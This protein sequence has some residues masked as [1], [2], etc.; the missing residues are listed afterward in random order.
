MDQVNIRVEVP[1]T[2]KRTDTPGEHYTFGDFKVTR[3]KANYPHEA[4]EAVQN[5]FGSDWR[6]ADWND[7]REAWSEHRESITSVFEGAQAGPSIV[8]LNGEAQWGDRTYFVEDHNGF[9]AWLL[10]SAR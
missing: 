9:K 7:L 4:A 5:E 10:L 3:A 8:T 6:I 1:P 2:G